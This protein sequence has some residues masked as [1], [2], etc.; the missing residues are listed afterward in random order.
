[1]RLLLIYLACLFIV[2]CNGG[3]LALSDTK[4]LEGDVDMAL[5]SLGSEEG[6]APVLK[7]AAVETNS[8]AAEDLSVSKGDE[9]KDAEPQLR[10]RT[11]NKRK[12]RDSSL[13]RRS[14][15]KRTPKDS[16]LAVESEPDVKPKVV[17]NVE[18]V[19]DKVDVLF[20]VDGSFSTREILRSIP[21]RMDGFIPALDV[22]LDWRVG[23][24]SAHVKSNEDKELSS[25]ELDG[26]VVLERKYLTKGTVS[27]ERIFIDTLTRNEGRKRCAFPP[28]C[29]GF[30]ETPLLALNEYITS[31][32]RSVETGTRFI[33]EDA[34]L[35]VVLVT[36]NKEN[37]KQGKRVTADE[38]LDTIQQEFGSDKK[39]SV[40]TLTALDEACRGQLKQ[41]H[42]FAEG[43]RAGE[44]LLLARTTGGA[45]LSLCSYDYAAPL[46][47]AIQTSVLGEEVDCDACAVTGVISDQDTQV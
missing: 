22:S 24:I 19:N 20:V 30:K 15:G 45:S 18:D 43:N 27:K 41:D 7:P 5:F 38:V 10:V 29:R 2:G 6:A 21:E 3:D 40:H 46:A 36:D 39:F 17:E 8:E 32:T 37:K 14:F 1:M 13:P 4:E 28:Y 44:M 34:H 23:F 16:D 11:F 42:F 9:A 33:R 26:A 31:P 47:S 25:M 35:A 12:P